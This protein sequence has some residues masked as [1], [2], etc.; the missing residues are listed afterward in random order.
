[1][2][3]DISVSRTDLYID[4]SWVPARGGERF[5][6]FDP[7]TEAV[8]ASVA[9]ATVEDG[10]AALDAAERAA[11]GWAAKKP[12]ERGEILRR[13]YDIIM[14]EQ[15]RLAR[16]VTLENGK[17]LPDS[18]SEIAYAAEFFRWFAEEAVRNIGCVSRAPSSGARILVQHRSA[19]IAL[20]VTPWNYP[21]A[22]GTRKIAP[23]LAAGCTVVVKPASETPLTMLALMPLLEEAGVP[24]GVVN[25]IPTRR[26]A[27]VVNSLLGDPRI[28]VVSFTGSTQVGRQLLRAAVE[29]VV[30]PA[31]ELGGNAPFIVCADADLEPA[32]DGAMLAKMRN[33]GE[34]CTAANRFYVH[35]SLH[36][37]F[38]A[39]MGRR[40]AALTVGNGLT[41]GVDVGALIN[42]AARDKVAA[43]VEDALAKG[44]RLVTGG[45]VPEGRGYFY[46][47][48]VL[49]GVPDDAD[50]LQ[51]EVFGPVA[52][53]QRFEDEREVI[54]KANAT[55]YGLAAYVYTRDLKRGLALCEQLEFGMVG[56]NR[57]LV[58][59]PAA[60]FGGMKQSGIGRE[61][62]HEGLMEF[63][64]TQYVSV[65]W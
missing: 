44:A 35:S 24:P 56:L 28:R 37:R 26:S 16:L 5:E 27:A 34:A 51:E 62:A 39:A 38:A 4:G 14:R 57:G 59:D 13:A 21:A 48:T 2:L 22:M 40:M 33:L 65:E 47:P 32:V 55:E 31:M 53:I 58:S 11:A 12:R 61:G 36:D 45:A 49:A 25:V 18:M 52:V 15:E 41:P 29:T 64:E 6:V 10:R 19:G 9:S 30:T 3:Q 17:A 8:L 23:A 50:C 63:L 1:M 60:P 43:L 20:L 46:S 42:R 54:A 7:A